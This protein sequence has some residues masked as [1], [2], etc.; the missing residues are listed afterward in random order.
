M[1]DRLV[2][3][4]EPDGVK[5]HWLTDGPQEKSGVKVDNATDEPTC[6]R[7]PA[8]LPLKEKAWNTVRL[9][10]VGDTV[11]VALNGTE[12]Y[13]RAVEATNQRFFGLFHY[14][15]R[16]EA[17]VRSMTYAG[18]WPKTCHRTRSCSRRSDELRSPA[19]ARFPCRIDGLGCGRGFFAVGVLL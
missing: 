2:F 14:T 6:R 16:T 5:L 13:E 10:V 12:V 3:V 7:G 11:K 8:K 9:A 18:D 1:L 4:L 17:R 15:D 19:T